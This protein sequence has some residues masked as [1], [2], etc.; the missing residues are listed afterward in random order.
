MDGVAEILATLRDL[1][2]L[3]AA[4]VDVG[5]AHSDVPFIP[6][7]PGPK[8]PLAAVDCG[9][10]RLGET[11]GGVVVALRASLVVDSSVQLFRTGP[12]LLPNSQKAQVLFRIGHDL[13]Q[14]DLLVSSKDGDLSLRRG[15]AADA[16]VLMDRLRN[17]LERRVQLI[18]A[19][20]IEGGL[21]LFDGALTATT[22]DTPRRYLE[23]LARV[24][25]RHGNDLV[26]LSKESALDVEG[27][28]LHY[29]LDDVPSVP[30]YRL[31][32]PASSRL[33]GNVFAAR[34][35]PL[36]PTLRVDV[37]G[38]D[39]TLS[40]LFGSATLRGGYPEVL[41][42]AHALSVFPASTVLEMRARLGVRPERE[43]ALA[44]ALG[45]FDE[46]FR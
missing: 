46:R 2:R 45:P 8:V 33:L 3:P 1:R 41:A 21:V 40:R 23:R 26:A 32:A 34:L 25:S 10:A 27:V 20:S 17:W 18:A 4:L 6:F 30:G 11:R 12:L 39:A 38:D 15:A 43:L 7:H 13:G 16:H 14:A 31:V 36:G 22:R 19:R 5:Y 24:A 37:K 44:G 9:V 29:R 28:P 42:R 35:S